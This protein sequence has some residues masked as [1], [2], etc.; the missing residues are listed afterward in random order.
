[1]VSAKMSKLYADAIPCCIVFSVIISYPLS[2]EFVIETFIQELVRALA[3][4]FASAIVVAYCRTIKTPTS[5]LF[6]FLIGC[7]MIFSAS[8]IYSLVRQYV[9]LLVMPSLFCLP[10][11][12]LGKLLAEVLY[13]PEISKKT[14]LTQE[15]EA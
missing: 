2:G 4:L 8:T 15:T 12:V 6:A 11:A 3:Y 5:W 7:T 1:M 10:G 14:M 9:V 13:S